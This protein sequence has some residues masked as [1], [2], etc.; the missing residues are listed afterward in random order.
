MRNRVLID[1]GPLVAAL[2]RA[3]ATHWWAIDQFQQHPSPLLTCEAVLTEAAYLLRREGV[4][5]DAL[6]GLLLR[7]VLSIAFE[8]ER[9][10]EALNALM[11]TYSN[12]PMDFADACLVR[13]SELHPDSRIMTL[14]SDF[15]IY[16]RYQRE[17]IPVIR[18]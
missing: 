6:F 3:Q 4:A 16:R 8:V 7:G 18:P 17:V 5:V 14:D 15:D 9:E 11:T 10:A 2:D 12:V 13:M 1:T